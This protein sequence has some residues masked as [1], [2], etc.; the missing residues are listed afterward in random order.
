MISPDHPPGG[1]ISFKASCLRAALYILFIVALMQGVYNEAG[2]PIAVRFS[3]RGFTEY[4]QSLLLGLS[5][6]LL[7]YLYQGL[8]HFRCLA[9][10]MFAFLCASLIREQDAFLDEYVFD[11]A[12]QVLVTLVVL[13][14]LF[15]V[16][17]NRQAFIE[18]FA[19][20]ADSFSF[21]LFAAGFLCTYVF[22]RLFGRSEFWETLMQ[23]NFI[24][25]FKDLAEEITEL[26]GYALLLFAVI[27]LLLLA[28]RQLRQR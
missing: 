26:F 27:E 9:L 24:R 20:Y 23:E 3:E 21:G 10:L 4:M 28:R 22:S 15:V 25:I 13:P 17:R 11:G 6:L 1:G 8:R 18:E 2:N 7:I 5:S 16:I 19:R 14:C 12:W